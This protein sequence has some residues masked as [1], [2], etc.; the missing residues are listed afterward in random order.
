LKRIFLSILLGLV[1]LIPAIAGGGQTS[2]KD[3]QGYDFPLGAPPQRIVSLAPN[4][5]EILYA[6]G[7]GK[8][9]VGVT[10][11]CDFPPEALTK[12]KIGGLIDPDLERIR[13]LSPDLIV[14]FRGNPL[15][16]VQRMRSLRLPVFVLEM[17]QT[18][19]SV[20]PFLERIGRV[21]RR[22]KEAAD[23]VRSLRARYDAVRAALRCDAD[24]PRLFLS[25]H[26]LGLWTC[27]RESY[28]TDMA[29]KAGG[30]SIAAGVAKRWVSYG[31]EQLLRDNPEVFVVLIKSPADFVPAREWLTGQPY[32]QSL[33]AVKTGLIYP[34]DENKTSR[35]GPRL[36]DA[37]E[38]LARVLHPRCF[39][40]RQG[41]GP[42]GTA[43]MARRS[44]PGKQKIP[45]NSLPWEPPRRALK[46]AER[47]N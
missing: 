47:R 16:V 23:L 28:L 15:P 31:R 36:F 4:I 33:P 37:L 17:G 35:Y 26:G 5:T 20:L 9:I 7:L 30:A 13:A 10:R 21:T 1:A 43:E 2:I 39:G 40:P 41:K 27:G 6:L 46:E 8:E 34:L 29:D 45:W 14:A 42:A 22:E 11:Y 18:V 44:L 19:E 38:E 12:E 3:D 32:L 24:K 25:L